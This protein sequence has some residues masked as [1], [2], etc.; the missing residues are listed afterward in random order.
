MYPS[1]WTLYLERQYSL[2]AKKVFLNKKAIFDYRPTKQLYLIIHL[3][4]GLPPIF[5]SWKMQE[6]RAACYYSMQSDVSCFCKRQPENVRKKKT[7]GNIHNFSWKEFSN[8]K[9]QVCV[10]FCRRSNHVI[11]KLYEKNSPFQE[12][13]HQNCGMALF[14][15]LRYILGIF[16]S[17]IS[18]V[19]P[20]K[21]G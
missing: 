4:S 13:I 6:L 5:S 10:R 17:L 18:K 21:Y 20:L 8:W 12:T 19:F 1:P 2:Y 15:W 11:K 9:F 3:L 7:R 16:F 14:K